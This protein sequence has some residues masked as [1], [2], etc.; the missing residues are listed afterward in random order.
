M[1]N[2]VSEAHCCRPLQE[3]DSAKVGHRR[4]CG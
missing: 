1:C 3:F 2:V 4:G